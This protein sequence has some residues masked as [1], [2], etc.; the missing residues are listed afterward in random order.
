MARIILKGYVAS[1]GDIKEWAIG[2]KKGNF[3]MIG[4]MC[5]GDEIPLQVSVN[6]DDIYEVKQDI[7]LPVNLRA[8]K[9]TGFLKL[10][11]K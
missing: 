2:G 4:I 3:R 9:K 5:E 7:E 11:I 1:V 8:D 10:K 6:P